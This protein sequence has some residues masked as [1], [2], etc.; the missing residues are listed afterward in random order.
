M[1]RALLVLQIFTIEI[2][3]NH[4]KVKLASGRSHIWQFNTEKSQGS[5]GK[6]LWVKIG[7]TNGTLINGKKD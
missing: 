7:T 2:L 4:A 6:W 1:A 3:Q 5:S